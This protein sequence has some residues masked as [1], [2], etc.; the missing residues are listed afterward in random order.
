MSKIK[1]PHVLT[2]FI[3]QFG[4]QVYYY[5]H[6]PIHLNSFTPLLFLRAYQYL[7]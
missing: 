4:L 6:C 1:V 3:T 2:L 7:K 5:N